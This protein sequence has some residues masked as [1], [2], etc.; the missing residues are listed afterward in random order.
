MLLGSARS[1]LTLHSRSPMVQALVFGSLVLCAALLFLSVTP[2][3][4]APDEKSHF[5]RVGGI[6]AGS[7]FGKVP[8]AATF[9][10][11]TPTPA[12]NERVRK[13]AGTYAL[14]P[15]FNY[16]E[17]VG[18]GCNAFKSLQPACNSP[19]DSSFNPSE[20]RFTS[21]HARAQPL[22]YVLPAIASKV[23]WSG[24]STFFLARFAMALQCATALAAAWWLV[25]RTAH[26][27]AEATPSGVLG[28][29]LIALTPLTVSLMGVLAPSA[30]ETCAALGLT[31][32]TW[33]LVR[34]P[35][36]PGA[37]WFSPFSRGLS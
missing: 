29:A 11:L 14:S 18:G 8:D 35:T 32:A 36:Q 6:A 5:I 12:Q 10:L 16:I 13:E 24:R 17:S 15:E 37:S 33:A 1:G 23:G 25:A 31:M 34:L 20:T 30:F 3:A 2:P 4:S 19:T 9:P 27:R 7:P 21:L 26:R 28:P 22:P